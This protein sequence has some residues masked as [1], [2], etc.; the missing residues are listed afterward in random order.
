M[1]ASL[2]WYNFS[3]V[4]VFSFFRQK[5]DMEFIHAF[6]M[7]S[8]C[9]VA[10]HGTNLFVDVA[11]AVNV[12]LLYA[13]GGH[14]SKDRII[15]LSGMAVIRASASRW[16][17]CP[18]TAGGIILRG[19]RCLLDGRVIFRLLVRICDIIR[20]HGRISGLFL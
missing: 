20:G 19:C 6:S 3:S 10:A 14:P 2:F 17:P 8:I 12:V 11:V 5:K 4:M 18:G 13:A 9:L 16:C 15:D 1:E 7:L